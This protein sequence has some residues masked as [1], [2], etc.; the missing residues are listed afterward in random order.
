[1][2]GL[3]PADPDGSATIQST[4]HPEMQFEAFEWLEQYSRIYGK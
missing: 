1:M 3:D 2:R 4:M